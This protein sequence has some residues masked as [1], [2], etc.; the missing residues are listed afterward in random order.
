MR[1]SYA[2]AGKS[3]P[4]DGSGGRMATS[5][6][7]DLDNARTLSAWVRV[8]D[9]SNN[10][11]TI[12]SGY[13]TDSDYFMLFTRAN[14]N[15]VPLQYRRNTDNGSSLYT[16]PSRNIT[17]NAWSHIVLVKPSGSTATDSKGGNHTNS[18]VQSLNAQLKAL[19]IFVIKQE[20]HNIHPS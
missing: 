6:D 7:I 5:L 19:V 1:F 10:S 11:Y 13:T 12:F 3:L 18:T 8:N 17:S 15:G 14:L 2:W 20:T 16:T 4:F 9:P